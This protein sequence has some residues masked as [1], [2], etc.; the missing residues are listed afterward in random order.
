[1]KEWGPI[2]AVILGI[3]LLLFFSEPLPQNLLYHDFADQRSMFGMLHTL[4]VLSNVVFCFAGI[5]GFVLIATRAAKLSGINIIYLVFFAGIFFT[6]LG[7]AYYHWSPDNTTLVWDR[8]PMTIGF[9]AFTS[10]VVSERYS[11]SLGHK[12][13]PWLLTVGFLSVVYWWWQD[14]LRP[15]FVVQ[16]GPMLI[17]PLIIWRFSGPGTVW[18]WLTIGFYVAAKIPELFDH[19]VFQF[20]AGFVSG[21]TVK[22][23]LAAIGAFMI[24]A[25]VKYSWG[26]NRRPVPTPIG[27]LTR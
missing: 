10:V 21:H 17:L 23:L 3:A 6:G 16:F 7:S 19:Q 13:F 2:V 11:E 24:V 26:V 5:W 20:T 18:L 25:K 8:L 22:H 14:D 12:L 4:N 27:A 15:Y 9:M 1:V